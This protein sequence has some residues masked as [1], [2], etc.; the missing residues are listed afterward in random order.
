MKDYKETLNLPKTDFPMKANLTKREPIILEKWERMGIYKKMLEKNKGG[1]VFVLHDGPPYAN[2]HIHMGTALNKILKDI[3][4][5]SKNMDGYYTPYVPG[6]DCHGLPIEFQVEKELGKKK[7]ELEVL[8]FRRKCRAFAEKFIDIQRSEFKRL[9]VFGEWD[10]P[11]ITMD[12]VYEADIVRE[13]GKFVEGGYVYIGNKP[14]Y[15]CPNCET[16][17][18]EAEVE[19]GDKESPSIYVAFPF[20]D[21]PGSRIDGLKGKRSFV[22]I[23][24]T[25]PWTIPANLAVCLHPDADYVGY[26]VEGNTYIVAHYLLPILEEELGWKGEIVA[27]F[28]GKDLEGLRL[29]HPLY[30]KDSLIIVGDHVTLDT[31]TGCVHTAPGHGEEDYEI[32]LKYNLPIYAPVDEKGRFTDDVE[33][34]KG[35]NVFSANRHVVDKLREFGLLLKEGKII[36][37]YPHCWRCK[38]PVIFRATRQWF[39][40]IDH[41]ELRKKLLSTIEK[42]VRW[43]PDWGK[44][45]IYSMVETRPDWCISRQRFWGVPIVAFYCR[46]CGALQLSRDICEHVARI[47]EEHG[48]D[49]WFSM[50]EKDLLPDGYRCVKC[51]GD[52]FVKEKDILDVWF[53][54]G[55]SFA[56]V[57]ERR[58]YLGFPSDMYLEGSDQHRGW[59][60]SSL[61]CSVATRGEPPYREILTHGFVVDGKG[62]KMSKSLGNVILPEEIINKYGAEILRLWVSAE[63][64]RD[65]VRISEEILKRNVEVYRRVRNTIRFLL[66][67]LYD[68]EPERDRVPYEK[69]FEIDRWILARLEL[70][71]RRV[72]KAYRE[73][74]FHIVYHSIHNFCVVDLSSLYLDILKDRLYIYPPKSLERRS[75]QS[76][77]YEILRTLLPLICPIFSFTAEEAWEHMPGEK[78]ESIFLEHFPEDNDNYMDE[79]LLKRWDRL[80]EVREMVTKALEEARV[81]KTIGHSLDAEVF[82]QLPPEDYELFKGWGEEN[83]S[84]Y[85][86]VSKVHIEKGD[87]VSVRVD[88]VKGEKCLRCW[89]YGD[90]DENGLCKR[91]FSILKEMGAI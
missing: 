81:K 58:K 75:S 85:F 26:E 8:D 56:A 42:K 87:E 48:A 40:S 20:K 30:D 29:K 19:Y 54:S 32:G 84:Y 27:R 34:F 18:A 44:N 24:T 5:K 45:R 78:S 57:L 68:F 52:S 38:E 16:A 69:L 47:F 91:C 49:V 62:R 88:K 10:N 51:G 17:L 39:I 35:M 31:G 28:Q 11:Y 37:S 12:Y 83:L 25:T 55:V 4:I 74:R 76:A 33:F 70:L 15:W 89:R 9:G 63:D 80:L 13:F 59:F 60:H 6:W 46:N 41:N 1:K 61:I 36:H 50:D 2:G 53:D 64:Y 77:I 72:K 7:D 43:I 67:N 90:V 82:L 66:G 65:D 73:Y 71:K 22:V 79:E 3:I 23:W 21:D 86:I 14:V